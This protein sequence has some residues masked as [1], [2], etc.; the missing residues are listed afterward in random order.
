MAQNAAIAM[1]LTVLVP[2]SGGSLEPVAADNDVELLTS[3]TSG[4]GLVGMVGA[5]GFE[6][7]DNQLIVEIAGQ[8]VVVTM[9]LAEPPAPFELARSA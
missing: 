4:S 6:A 7:R 3:S 1:G 2:L 8:R 9:R 5:R